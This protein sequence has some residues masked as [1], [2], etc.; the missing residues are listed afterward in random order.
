MRRKFALS[1]A[2]AGVMALAMTMAAQTVAA[3]EETWDGLVKI[4]AKRVY[5]AYLRPGADFRVYTEVVIDQPV[6][7]FRKNWQRDINRSASTLGQRLTSSDVERIRTAFTEGFAE[8]LAA[9]FAKGGWEVGLANGP[10][11]L[12][13]TPLLVNVYVNAPDRMSAARTTTYTVQAGEATLALEIRDA[14]TG[15]LLGRVIDRKRT[16][17]YGNTLMITNRV[18]NRA[19]FER[20]LKGWTEILV[21]GLATLKDASPLGMLAEDQ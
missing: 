4:D 11:V 8:I 7:E 1:I 17:N 15:Q 20:M 9:G 13:V 3:E 6:V 16:S 2:A 10:D 12:R 14:E 18:T 19:E 5:T 21:D